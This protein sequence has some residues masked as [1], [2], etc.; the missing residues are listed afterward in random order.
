MNSDDGD[1]QQSKHPAHVYH[2]LDDLWTTQGALLYIWT[3]LKVNV[4]PSRA[5]TSMKNFKGY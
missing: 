4:T 2:E 3:I 5:F 1:E